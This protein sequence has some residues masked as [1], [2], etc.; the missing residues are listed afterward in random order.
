MILEDKYFNICDKRGKNILVNIF[1]N[2][3]IKQY[4]FMSIDP[5]AKM[6]FRNCGEDKFSLDIIRGAIECFF[7]SNPC[8][9]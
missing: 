8:S 3:S 7:R 5:P 6:V 2:E 9:L 1:Y 4:I